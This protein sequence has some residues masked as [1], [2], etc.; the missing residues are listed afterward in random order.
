MGERP[1]IPG[2]RSDA[3]RWRKRD[4]APR[5]GPMWWLRGGLDRRA[6]GGRG[7]DGGCSTCPDAGSGDR[8][9]ADRV[10]LCLRLPCAA[11]PCGRDGT[12]A[13]RA[14]DH[15][16]YRLP[17]RQTIPVQEVGHGRDHD[18]MGCPPGHRTTSAAEPGRRR[19]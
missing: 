7:S 10:P 5:A 14:A 8:V 9:P 1:G 18:R 16:Y 11:R 13:V 15:R 3:S 19:C 6:G 4:T 12:D 2:R 17:L